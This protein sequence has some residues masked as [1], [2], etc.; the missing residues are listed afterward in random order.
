MMI[1][2]ILI[3]YKKTFFEKL[4]LDRLRISEK[5]KF[6]FSRDQFKRFKDM[7]DEH[8]KTIKEVEHTLDSLGIAYVKHYRSPNIKYTQFDLIIAIGG[9]GTVLRASHFLDQQMILGVNSDPKRSVGK[10]CATD[11]HGFSSMFRLIISGKKRPV[12]VQRLKLDKKN[13]KGPILVL[14]DILVCDRNPAAVSRYILTASKTKEYQR[15]SGLWVSTAAGST[16]AMKSAGGRVL[17]ID[18]KYF[19]YRPREPYYK[20]LNEFKLKGGI[21]SPQQTLKIRSNMTQGMMY[22]DGAHL[23]VPFTFGDQARISLSKKPLFLFYR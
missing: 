14:N 17:N 8:Q 3:V 1:K 10:F 15:S 22:I 21:I 9:D 19:Q 13:I 4:S 6:I 2:K 7:H 16:G 12:K 20:R 23:K 18:S 11:R 5:S